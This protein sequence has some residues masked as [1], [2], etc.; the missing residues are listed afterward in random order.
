MKGLWKVRGRL[1]RCALLLTVCLLFVGLCPLYGSVSA[2]GDSFVHDGKSY[3]RSTDVPAI[4]I[5]GASGVNI[6][7]YVSCR[8]VAIDAV[9]GSYQE[10]VD[11]DATI[12]IRGNST[13]SGAKKPYNIKF[14]SK[15]NLFGMGKGKRY[16][17]IA[18]LYDPTLIRNQ[19]V[20]DFARGM[21]AKYTPD[22]MLVD[23]YF[24][25]KYAG[26]Y[27]L[28]EAISD[29]SGRV[30]IDTD[31]GD[32]ILERDV[33]DDPGR[34][35][36]TSSL[37]FQFGITEPDDTTYA[38]AKQVKEKVD[39]AEKVLRGGN[40]E[41]VLQAF[42]IPSFVDNYICN[43]LFKNVDVSTLSS[44]FYYKDGK[45]YAGP[46]WDFDL[47]AGNCDS[48]YYVS[49]NNSYGDSAQGIWCNCIWFKYLLQY[50]EF[51]EALYTRYLELQDLIVNLYADNLLGQNYIDRT[52]ESAS[53]SITRNF[54]EAGWNPGTKYS[55]YMRIPEP[56]FEENVEYF[57]AWLERRNDWLLSYWKLTDRVAPVP[58]DPALSLADGYITGFP[59][60]TLIW[61][62]SRMFASD[63][64]C[65]ANGMFVGTGA[66]INGGGATYIAV[67]DGDLD[68]DGQVSVIDY[69]LLRQVVRGDLTPS[70]E[71]Y[72]A[73]CLGADAP[74]AKACEKIKRYCTEGVALTDN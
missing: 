38:Q 22:S 13:S 19:A 18:N 3:K 10:V 40:Y 26:C 36:I 54:S 41:K 62:V 20:F 7:T 55:T 31:K 66:W 64:T 57:R 52:I 6:S 68:G 37:G 35:Y 49:Y 51:K 30:D 50:S 48:D 11:S 25:G 23:V 29:G 5:E 39:Q 70:R 59:P 67:V 63:V 74:G 53:K 27:Q 17:L 15:I 21:G 33:R 47:S 56:T 8:V 58:T 60:R 73:G 34:T 44:H 69:I 32:F 1:R 43:E 2:A 4:Y 71:V 24:N 12:R 28:C 42:D 72:L 9:G 45:M 61:W 14:S 65:N 46:V 16:C